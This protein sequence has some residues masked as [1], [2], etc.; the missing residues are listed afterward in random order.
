MKRGTVC[1]IKN[2]LPRVHGKVSVIISLN[3]AP[4]VFSPLARAVAAHISAEFYG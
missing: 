2:V 3:M 4:F 1:L